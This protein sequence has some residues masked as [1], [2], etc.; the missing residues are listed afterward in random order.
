ME[1]RYLELEELMALGYR[2][3]AIEAIMESQHNVS[4]SMVDKMITE[5][6]DAWAKDPLTNVTKKREAQ[7][8]RLLVSIRSAEKVSQRARFESVYARVA[9]TFQAGPGGSGEPGE[10]GETGKIILEIADF[11]V[12]EPEPAAPPPK[13]PA[14]RA[15]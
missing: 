4:A 13:T 14:K 1:R 3:P 15:K 7:E 2:R 5:V 8:R 6:Y 10:N 11:R 9:G 12:P